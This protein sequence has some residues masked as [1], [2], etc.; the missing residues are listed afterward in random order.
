MRFKLNSIVA[1]CAL[2]VFGVFA[3]PTSAGTTAGS[4]LFEER[5]AKHVADMNVEV[6]LS[7]FGLKTLDGGMTYETVLKD[8]LRGSNALADAEEYIIWSF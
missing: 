3:S 1:S 5:N 4:P 6:G 7:F 2:V 8:F